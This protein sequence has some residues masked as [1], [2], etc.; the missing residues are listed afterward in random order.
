MQLCLIL[1]LLQTDLETKIEDWN[2]VLHDEFTIENR[3]YAIE[4]YAITKTLPNLINS[5]VYI[6]QLYR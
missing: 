1:F 2:W 5:G 4:K 6:N 3:V